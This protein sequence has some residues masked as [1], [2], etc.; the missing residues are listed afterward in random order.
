M[1]TLTLYHLPYSH[2]SAKA[3]VVLIEKGVEFDAQNIHEIGDTPYSDINPSAQVPF[4]VVD[5]LQLGE[6]EV[7]VEWLNDAYP[8]P[9]ML[10]QSSDDKARSRLATRIHDLYVAPDLSVLFGQLGAEERDADLIEATTDNI[11][12][13]LQT[14]EGLLSDGPYFSGEQFGI[15][16]ASFAMSIWYSYW[17]FDQLGT[18]QKLAPLTKLQSWFAALEE[19]PSVKCVF[20]ECKVAL[21]MSEA[22]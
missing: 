22:A 19:R 8:E 10:P 2:F 6:S 15:A 12:K 17:L 16:D 5:D 4:L 20:D 9:A 18:S 21:G 11:A 14:V 13:R 3:K 7:I 1:S